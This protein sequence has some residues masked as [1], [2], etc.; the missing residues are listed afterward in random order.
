VIRQQVFQQTL[1]SCLEPVR[2]ELSDPDVGE[3]M[4]NGPHE[5]FVERHGRIE[6]SPARFASEEALLAAL[7]N[8]AQYAGRP[9]GPEHCILE[10]HLPDGS[11]VEAILPPASP[12]GP[13]VSIRRFPQASPGIA[14]LVERGSLTREA[15]TLLQQIVAAKRNIVVAGGTGSGKTSLLNALSSF[16]PAGE[17]VVVIEDARELRLMQAHVVQLEAQPGDARGRGQITIRQ[18]FRASLRMRPDRIVVG[19]VRGGE[20]FDLIQAM[21]SGH[22]GCMSTLHASSPAD[23][24]RRLE[25]LALLSGVELP[26][27]ALRAQ[28]AAAVNIVVQ[29]SRTSE[30]RRVVTQI[31][32][33]EASDSGYAL[34]C[35][36][37]RSAHT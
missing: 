11:R 33:V 19:E 9:L 13:H 28:L 22:G 2:A 26:L 34:R 27:L 20:A 30:G 4:I 15:A 37:E 21:T 3:I 6:A 1:L 17:R 16:I 24:L 35:V 7:R 23:A 25:T 36:F 14:E 18:L 10:A 12:R 31:A 32:E 29:V 5:V 8:I